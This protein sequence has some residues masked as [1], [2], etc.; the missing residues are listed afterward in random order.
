LPSE[1]EWNYAASGGSEQ[2]IFP[3]GAW[4]PGGNA[5]LAIYG[6]WYASGGRYCDM[7]TDVAPVGSAPAGNARWG[8]S[9]LAGNVWEWNLDFSED[10]YPVPCQDCADLTDNSLRAVRGGS[11]LENS[12]NQFTSFRLFDTPPRPDY[13]RGFRCARTP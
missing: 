11:Y 9:D 13:L 8:Q 6:C 10:P 12:E 7:V 3:W 5:Q 2:R 1:A 4:E